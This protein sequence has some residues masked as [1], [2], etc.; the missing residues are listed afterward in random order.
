[1]EGV[2]DPIGLLGSRLTAEVHIIKAGISLLRNMERVVQNS[3][4]NVVGRYT[5]SLASAEAV[6]TPEEIEEGVLVIDMGAGL[7]DFAVFSEGALLL[8][9]TVPMGGLSITKDIAHFMKINTEQAER[10]KIESGYALADGVNEGERIKIKPRGEEREITISRRQLAEV[11]QIRLE[12]IMERVSGVINAQG[13]NL[14]ALNAGIVITGGGAKLMG[15]KEFLERY[16]DLPVRVGYPTGVVGLKEKVQDPAY[17]TSVGLLRLAYR[18]VNVER[19]KESK[20]VS[21][22]KG[23]NTSG[24]S[25]WVEKVKSFFRDI[26]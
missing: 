26:L 21:D 7:T 15:I 22:R 6:L 16:F 9:G 19:L 5:S 13:V 2:M 12:E 1:Q 25:S 10:V 24:L 14:D 20:L 3:G 23:E 11:I 4:V 17:A 8:T 18:D